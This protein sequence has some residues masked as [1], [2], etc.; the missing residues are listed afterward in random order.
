MGR[1]KYKGADHFI[2]WGGRSMYREGKLHVGD[3]GVDHLIL[4]GGRSIIYGE[5]EVSVR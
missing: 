5:G 3:K 4:W 2:L 1:E